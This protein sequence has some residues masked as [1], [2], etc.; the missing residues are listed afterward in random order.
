M[1]NILCPI[2]KLTV[3]LPELLLVYLSMKKHLKIKPIKLLVITAPIFLLLCAVED[4]II[5]LLKIGTL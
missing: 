1:T 2:N 3:V 5:Y 4:I